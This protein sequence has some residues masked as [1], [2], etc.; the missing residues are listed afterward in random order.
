MTLRN[1]SSKG[2]ESPEYIESEEQLLDVLT[3]PTSTLV[4]FIKTLSSPLVVLGAGGK[5]GPTLAVLAKRAADAANHPLDVVGVSRFSD[6]TAQAWLERQGVRTLSCD[7]TEPGPL[8]GL[9]A[10]ENIIYLVG[11]KFGTSQNPASTWATNTLVPARVAE[12]YPGARIAAVSTG[13]VYPASDIR[14]GGSVET[15]SLTERQTT[16]A[17]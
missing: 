8:Q 7:L 16:G 13:N 14:R 3:R 9:P 5:M 4:D 1:S 15:D 11:Q 10:T 6:A 2:S 17:P 12:R